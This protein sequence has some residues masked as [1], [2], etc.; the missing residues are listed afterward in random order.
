MDIKLYPRPCKP[1]DG[2]SIYKVFA[3]MTGM[4][5]PQF[6]NPSR[7]GKTNPC[8]FKRLLGSVI[9]EIVN[10]STGLDLEDFRPRRSQR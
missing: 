5:F 3:A 9:D 7:C 10:A 1:F 2:I 4:T 6:L 8:S